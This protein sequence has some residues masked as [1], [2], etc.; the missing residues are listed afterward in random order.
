MVPALHGFP[1]WDFMLG[2]DAVN[3]DVGQQI[4]VARRGLGRI[5][6]LSSGINLLP[7]PAYILDIG[8]RAR[9]SRTRSGRIQTV[10]SARSDG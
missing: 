2:V 1:P 6:N 8:A 5:L 10:L 9:I 4:A 3:Y 7:P